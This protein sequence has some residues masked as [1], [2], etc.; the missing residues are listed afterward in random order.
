MLPHLPVLGEVATVTATALF[1]ASIEL[2]V[3]ISAAIGCGPPKD[4]GSLFESQVI[5]FQ[6][7]SLHRQNVMKDLIFL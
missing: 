2:G 4:N 5:V 3:T 7:V 1:Q 6:L